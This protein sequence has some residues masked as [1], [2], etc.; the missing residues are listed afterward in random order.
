MVV[1]AM[2]VAMAANSEEQTQTIYHVT[3]SLRNPASYT[4]LQETAH[5]ATSSTT[6]RKVRMASPSG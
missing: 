4:V 5:R 2:M 6:H 3:S 1:N